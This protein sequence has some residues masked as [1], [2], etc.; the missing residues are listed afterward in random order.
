MNNIILEN[1]EFILRLLE[2]DDYH[3]LALILQ[4]EQVMY[5]YEHAFSDEEVQAW[6]D[7]QLTRYQEDGFGLYALVLKTNGKMIGQCGLTSQRYLD[8]NVVEIG[9]LLNKDHWH[10][11]YATKA[12]RALK[13]YAFSV[14]GLDEVYSI[15]KYDNLPSQKV[16]LKNGM[17][18]KDKINKHYYNKDMIHYVYRIK[19]GE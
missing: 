11:G 3:D 9:Y 17:M 5:A 16:A 2:P 4:D 12:S 1:N 6:L 8:Q 19:R 15:I 13:E 14:L 10:Q 18:F 7:N